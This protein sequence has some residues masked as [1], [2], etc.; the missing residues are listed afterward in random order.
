MAD[1]QQNQPNQP[2]IVTSW[3]SD[4]DSRHRLEAA[5][6]DIQASAGSG[7]ERVL[8]I[9]NTHNPQQVLTCT[10][11]E[12]KQFAASVQQGSIGKM[13]ATAGGASRPGQ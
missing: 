13:L 9:H 2:T 5:L 3:V 4:D 10:E 1:Q 11:D 12:V 7:V 8:G 6:T